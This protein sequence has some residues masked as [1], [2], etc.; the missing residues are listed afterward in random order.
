MEWKNIS[1]EETHT[2]GLVSQKSVVRYVEMLQHW[3][4]TM[5]MG[6]TSTHTSSTQSTC[7]PV[8]DQQYDRQNCR[9]TF[10]EHPRRCV[11]AKWHWQ[12][13]V[14]IT[15]QSWRETGLILFVSAWSLL[16]DL[17]LVDTIQ[18]LDRTLRGKYSECSVLV[19]C[20]VGPVNPTISPKVGALHKKIT[21]DKLTFLNVK[22]SFP[23]LVICQKL[24]S[25]VQVDNY[26]G[27]LLDR[28]S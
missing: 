19:L 17:Q 9:K 7:F 14:M 6:R 18:F 8:I 20:S 28:T 15:N 11:Q 25:R 1:D 2:L 16:L 3:S 22:L 27:R 12:C 5:V 21:T 10:F 23:W 4:T 24:V 13:K 26:I